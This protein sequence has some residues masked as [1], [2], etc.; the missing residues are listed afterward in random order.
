MKINTKI[1]DIE[2]LTMKDGNQMTQITLLD[3]DSPA[4]KNFLTYNVLEEDKKIL[5][6]LNVGDAVTINV[7][8]KIKVDYDDNL[9]VRGDFIP[10]KK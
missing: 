10:A 2:T 9:K 7:R 3:A 4:I 5:Q 1:H 8:G 6:G